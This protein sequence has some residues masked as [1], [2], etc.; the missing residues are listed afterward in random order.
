V[1]WTVVVV[2][3]SWWLLHPKSTPEFLIFNQNSNAGKPWWLRLR[4]WLELLQVNFHWI[5]G[6]ILFA[7][8]VL[9]LG[10]RFP[11]EKGHLKWRIPVLLLA[12][13]G[14]VE[15]SLLLANRSQ[16][17][18]ETVV[19]STTGPAGAK[20][21]NDKALQKL[22]QSVLPDLTSTLQITSNSLNTATTGTITKS[23]NLQGHLPRRGIMLGTDYLFA[24]NLM[25]G[26]MTNSMTDTLDLSFMVGSL[27]SS[28]KHYKWLPKPLPEPFF[29]YF[30]PSMGLH[31]LAYLG[32]LGLAH[33]AGFQRRY[34]ERE[35][36]AV[37]LSAQLNEARLGALKAQLQPH[38]LFNALNGIATL[39]RR[40]PTA[41]HEM[42]VSLSEL[43]R[44]SLDQSERQQISLREEMEFIDRYM[45][46]QQMRFGDRLRFEK[47]IEPAVMDCPVP[48]LL[49]QPLAE[50]A[51]RHGIEPLPNAGLVLIR[52]ERRGNQLVLTVEDDGV[53]LPAGADASPLSSGIGLSSVRKRL[54]TLYPGEFQFQIQTR[55]QGGVS[56]QIILPFSA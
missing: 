16:V 38:F 29:N 36:Q 5:W 12:G 19:I 4:E 15:G 48:A 2:L 34:R 46:I 13:Y 22:I 49:L 40:D 54:E 51:I 24:T 14:F 32:L 30:Q 25:A 53:G 9:W 28:V 35:K 42:L 7:P 33:A 47:Q 21:T 26:V 56:V 23:T 37:L 1:A 41:A 20:N 52:A 3:V 43:L 39:V 27:S 11:L 18:T 50:N 31:S 44:L 55:P 10:Y 17:A 6:W 45:E 8:Y